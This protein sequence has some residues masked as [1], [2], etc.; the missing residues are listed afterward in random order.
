MLVY[1]TDP[2]KPGGVEVSSKTTG[3]LLLR[4]AP[5]QGMKPGSFN[6]SLTYQPDPTFTVLTTPN[7]TLLLTNLLSGTSY[8]ISLTATGPWRLQSEAVATYFITTSK[9]QITRCPLEV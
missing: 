8:N 9:L 5:A 2:N 6:Y 7:N 3:S 1:I 4:W